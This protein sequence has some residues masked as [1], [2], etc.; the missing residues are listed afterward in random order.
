MKPTTQLTAVLSML[1]NCKEVSERDTPFNGFRA[2]IADLR[3]KHGL[4]VKNRAVK[5]VNQFN[6][7]SEYNLY[8]I[9]RSAKPA[10]RELYKKLLKK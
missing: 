7:K 4:N 3:N 8:F 10:A 2:R 1:I 5:F 6:H 9:D